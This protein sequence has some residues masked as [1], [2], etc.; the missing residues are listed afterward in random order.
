MRLLLVAIFMFII[1][2]SIGCSSSSSSSSPAAPT[3]NPASLSLEFSNVTYQ[4]TDMHYYDHTRTFTEINGVG[5]TLTSAQICYESSGSCDS[6]TVD[7]RIEGDNNLV[8]T[9]KMFG[10]SASSNTFTLKYWGTDD[11]GNDVYIEQVMTVNGAT[12]T[13]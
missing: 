6:G 2:T 8:H 1:Q 12:H 4:Y 3:S 5:V 11:N 10:T 13:P 9:N 7:Y